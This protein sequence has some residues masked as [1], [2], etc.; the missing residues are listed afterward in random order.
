LPEETLA[1]AAARAVSRKRFSEAVALRAVYRKRHQP[2]VKAPGRD[3]G[4]GGS[5]GCL[6]RET[7]TPVGRKEYNR[8]PPGTYLP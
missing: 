6:P 4:G 2:A 8:S 7:L 3:F 1:A 5:K